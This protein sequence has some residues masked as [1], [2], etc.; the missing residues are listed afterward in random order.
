LVGVYR[1]K[2]CIIDFKQTNKMKK[3]EWIEDYFHQLA[4]YALAHDIVHGT[5]INTG[6]VLMASQQGGTEEF[7]TCGREFE[8]YKAQWLTRV[9]KFASQGQKPDSVEE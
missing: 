6:V 1:G 9:E 4:A 7:I 2:P 3:R 5:E 8:S